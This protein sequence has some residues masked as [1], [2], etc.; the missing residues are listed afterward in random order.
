MAVTHAL[1]LLSTADYNQSMLW[2]KGKDEQVRRLGI[3]TTLAELPQ[4]VLEAQD[5]VSVPDMQL[6]LLI[7]QPILMT[8]L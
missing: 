1:P 6:R 2:G 4:F 5:S 7:M 3:I 8:A